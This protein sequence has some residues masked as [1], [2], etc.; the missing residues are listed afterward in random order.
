MRIRTEVSIFAGIVLALSGCNSSSGSDSLAVTTVEQTLSLDPDGL[1]TVVVFGGSPGVMTVANFE[2]DGGQSAVIAVQA[3]AQYT[4]TWDARVTPSHRVRVVG[5]G[6]VSANWRSVTTSDDSVPSMVITDASQPDDDVLGGDTIE[7][8]FGGPRVVE[9]DAESAAS[10]TLSVDGVVLD[11]TGSVFDLDP[12]S[13]VLAITLG[14]LANLHA[15]FTLTASSLTSVADVALA[16]TPVTGTVTTLPDNSPPA[17]TAV[18]QNLAPLSGGDEFGR[19]VEVTFD[20]PMDPVSSI[21]LGRFAVED[22]VGAP[23]I[24]LVTD[25][26]QIAD[27]SL[28]VHFSGPV[29]PGVDR[30]ILVGLK[31]DHG[32]AFLN[33]TVDVEFTDPLGNAFDTVTA[34]QVQNTGG[35]T[36]VIVTEN[37]LDPDFAEVPTNWDLTVPSNPTLDVADQDF[38]YSIFDK[39]LT[40]AL[41]FDLLNTDAITIEALGVREVDGGL[42]SAIDSSATASGDEVGP[43]VLTV[44]QNR[45]VDPSGMTIDVTLDEH[46][47]ATAADVG[48]WTFSGGVSV[49]DATILASPSTVRLVADGVVLPG[50]ITLTASAT[51]ADL[52]GN[53]MADDPQSPFM[54]TSSDT[55]PPT[56]NFIVGSAIEGAGNDT[57]FVSFDDDMYESD[58][59][60]DSYWMAES[61]AGTPLDTIGVTVT[62]DGTSHTATMTLTNGANLKRGDDVRVS[63]TTMRDIGGNAITATSV[64]G[65]I[66]AEATLPAVHTVW[67]EPGTDRIEVRFTEPSD[68]LD[69]LYDSVTN[70]FGTRYAVRIGDGGPNDGDLRGY[71]SIATV[72][73]DGLG[74][75]LEYGF[76][77]DPSDKVDALGVTDLAG[78]YMFPAIGVVPVVADADAPDLDGSSTFGITSGERNDTI[79]VDFTEDMSPWRLLDPSNYTVELSGGAELDLSGARIEWDGA[80]AVVLDLRGT[81]V[82]NLLQGVDYDITVNVDPS[83]PIRTAQG[84]ELTAAISDTNVMAS[85]D[86]TIPVIGVSDA[87]IVVTM[88]PEDSNRVVL[89]FSEAVDRAAVEVAANYVLDGQVPQFALMIGPRT[90]LLQWPLPTDVNVGGLLTISGD[91][92]VDLAGNLSPTGP[93]DVTVALT[94]DVTSPLIAGTDGQ[95]VANAGGDWIEVRFDEQVIPSTALDSFNYTLTNGAVIDLTAAQFTYRSSDAAV[96]IR[97]PEGLEL[98]AAQPISIGVQGVSDFV[99]NEIQATITVGVSLNGGSDTTPPSIAEAFVNWREDPLG[100]TVDMLFSED[101]DTAFMGDP[102]NWTISGTGTVPSIDSVTIV[103]DRYARF[104][105]SGP[106]G[107]DHT[108]EITSLADLANN[109]ADTIT[110][111]PHD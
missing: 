56:P 21:Q 93:G 88:P 4:V 63:F 70:P 51:I 23:G 99:G 35:D 74:V 42:F 27:N 92:I 97:L 77:I 15:T 44:V 65:A 46:V 58:V 41:D 38:S 14:P 25:V 29:V 1:T 8:T 6:N 109:V 100:E 50:E 106:I 69:D 83:D 17:L 67:R 91:S 66:D 7:V 103:S 59:T 20:D 43:T 32:N 61:P 9:T 3:G 48:N 71:P 28:R 105:L 40:I 81:P 72:H 30:L 86:T 10:W 18:V 98:D 22:H 85:G 26:E 5:K 2:A 54:I 60:N 37:A 101:V 78:N 62:Y 57:I 13:Q 96:L 39:S 19:V 47:N 79:V 45:S 94:V 82:V 76:L 110:F 90:A 84:V 102:G 108:F 49:T 75:T 16:A 11:L 24:T 53:T 111:D 64:S 33:Q 55:V 107:S 31:D 87:R 95:A 36:I 52:A 12:T 80:Q 89:F 68:L 73:D 34:N 104:R